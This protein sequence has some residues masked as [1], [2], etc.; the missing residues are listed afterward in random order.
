MIILHHYI[1]IFMYIKL[2]IFNILEAQ[3]KKKLPSKFKQQKKKKTKSTL[4][5][6]LVN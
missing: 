4:L 6:F 1:I 5:Y 2:K 3:Q